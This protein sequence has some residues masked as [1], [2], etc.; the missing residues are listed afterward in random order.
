MN[1]GRVFNQT[2]SYVPHIEINPSELGNWDKANE[3]LEQSVLLDTQIRKITRVVDWL[4]MV[5]HQTLTWV[6]PILDWRIALKQ[7]NS[8]SKHLASGEVA[9]APEK[10]LMQLGALIAL[11]LNGIP[12]ATGKSSSHG[13]HQFLTGA[14]HWHN[15]TLSP[16]TWRV[17][18]SHQLLQS[19]SC[20]L[21]H[22]LPHCSM[23]SQM[24][25]TRVQWPFCNPGRAE[26][27]QLATL[28]LQACIET[29]L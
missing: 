21:V 28:L 5:K 25:P 23:G 12:N 7:S 19:S 22:W 9:P 15:P 27:C 4:S 17:E 13:S 14:L 24:L 29:S 16:N 6:A 3:Q 11:L 10:Q 2:S 20:N 1:E 26:V 8:Q 18:R